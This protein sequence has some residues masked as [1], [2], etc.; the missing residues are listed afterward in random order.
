MNVVVAQLVLVIDDEDE[1]GRTSP[2]TRPARKPML[3]YLKRKWLVF[4]EKAP[5]I[6]VYVRF[7]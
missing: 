3:G 4:K 7:Y 6:G 5:P 2:Q 1:V